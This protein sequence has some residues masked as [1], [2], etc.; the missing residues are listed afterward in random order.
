MFGQLNAIYSY[1]TDHL[2]S[3]A[4]IIDGISR[5]RQNREPIREFNFYNN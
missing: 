1:Y 2:H 4:G 5:I 3:R